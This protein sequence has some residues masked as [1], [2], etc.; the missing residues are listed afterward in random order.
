M[1]V[2]KSE[3]MRISRI[4]RIRQRI[5]QKIRPL[6]SGYRNGSAAQPPS[7][8]R[9]PAAGAAGLNCERGRAGGKAASDD[10]RGEII[11]TI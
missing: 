5:S 8:S 3:K 10:S 2:R 4:W 9:S 7:R 1:E 11:N 6:N